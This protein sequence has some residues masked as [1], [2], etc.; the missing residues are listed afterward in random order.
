M[1]QLMCVV[2]HQSSDNIFDRYH[3]LQ[4]CEWVESYCVVVLP[5]MP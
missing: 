5:Q 2:L 3:C 4:S 1:P